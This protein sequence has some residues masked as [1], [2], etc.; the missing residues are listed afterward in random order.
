MSWVQIYM[1]F[2]MDLQDLSNICLFEDAIYSKIYIFNFQDLSDMINDLQ[3][4]SGDLQNHVK[5]LQERI[6]ILNQV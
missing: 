4:N 2:Q 1:T 6:E 3:H 5:S